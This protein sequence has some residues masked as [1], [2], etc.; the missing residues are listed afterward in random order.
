MRK[1]SLIVVGLAVLIGAVGCMNMF[2]P[3][4]EGILS[5]TIKPGVSHTQ[6]I[7]PK[8]IPE[9]AEYVRI[10]VWHPD[11]GFFTTHTVPVDSQGT[12]IEVIVPINNDYVID[13][14]SYLLSGSGNVALT[15]DRATGVNVAAG[16]TSNVNVTLAPWKVTFTG[17]STV[18]SGEKYS[19]ACSITG[20]GGLI[21]DG[22][23]QTFL[24]M[25]LTGFQDPSV[26]RPAWVGYTTMV[27]NGTAVQLYKGTAPEVPE[28]ATLYVVMAVD[29]VYQAYGVTPEQ[30][31]IMLELP[32]RFMGE[33]IH[34]ITVTPPG[35]GVV[36][37]VE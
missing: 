13:V 32:N 4:E 25:S 37:G 19:L 9:N 15:G 21:E 23:Y 10:F 28:E 24:G 14:V 30:D 1:A 7:K 33:T 27:G 31:L 12:T 26:T 6:S 36:I 34:Q 16:A 5:I 2:K 20:G 11:T 3:Q 29:F 22:L 35:G 17:D 18:T 8:L